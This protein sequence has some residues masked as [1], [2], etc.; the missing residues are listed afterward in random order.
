V[1]SRERE[2]RFLA[3]ARQRSWTWLHRHPN[4]AVAFWLSFVFTADL[5]E[6]QILRE[7]A[8]TTAG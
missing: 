3:L 1:D 5:V 7:R 4:R 6:E 8:Q 2:P